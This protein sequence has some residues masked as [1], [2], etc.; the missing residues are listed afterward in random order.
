MFDYPRSKRADLKVPCPC[1]KWHRGC[2][3]TCQ[4]PAYLEGEALR[5]AMQ[6]DRDARTKERYYAKKDAIRRNRSR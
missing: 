5:K 1:E 2:H 3:E 6:K 4:D